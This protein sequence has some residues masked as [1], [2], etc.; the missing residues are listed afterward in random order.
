M[1]VEPT[2][3]VKQKV[4][5]DKHVGQCGFHACADRQRTKYHKSIFI[6]DAAL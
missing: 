3:N 4:P 2:E 6:T 1:V 5:I